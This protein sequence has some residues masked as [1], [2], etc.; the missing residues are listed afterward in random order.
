[1][2]RYFVPATDGTAIYVGQPVKLVGSATTDGVAHVTA[3]T[4]TAD[5]I[6]GVV[7]GVEPETQDSTLY[8]VASTARYLLVADDP[9]Q[10]FEIQSD[11]VGGVTAVGEVAD[12]VTIATGSTVTGRSYIEIGNSSITNNGDQT[13]DVHIIGVP[14]RVDNDITTANGRY[15]VRFLNHAYAIDNDGSG[16]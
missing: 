4:T 2:N 1:V 13:E 9:A 3:M 10:V 7:V 11:G 8:R 12:L 16:V 5:V 15:L 14:Q 6:G